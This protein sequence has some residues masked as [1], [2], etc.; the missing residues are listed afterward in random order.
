[1][2]EIWVRQVTASFQSIWNWRHGVAD[3][4][5]P[6]SYPVARSAFLGRLRAS[7]SSAASG[8]P[9]DLSVGAISVTSSQRAGTSY[10]PRQCCSSRPSPRTSMYSPS[11]A[12]PE[13][14]LVQEGPGFANDLEAPRAMGWWPRYVH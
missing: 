9:A 4:D 3:V 10:Q 1:M 5:A 13:E 12:G 14:T 7:L 6:W 2:E 11:T 8:L